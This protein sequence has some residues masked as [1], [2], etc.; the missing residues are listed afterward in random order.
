VGSRRKSNENKIS[1]GRQTSNRDDDEK[2]EPIKRWNRRHRFEKFSV[3]FSECFRIEGAYC[4]RKI[5]RKHYLRRL[6]VGSF[7]R[8]WNV[9]SGLF[10]Q[11]THLIEQCI[12]PICLSVLLD[13]LGF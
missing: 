2:I 6:L 4:S 9:D 8:K 7:F 3:E 1:Q 10:R 12:Q 13:S 11:T 5:R